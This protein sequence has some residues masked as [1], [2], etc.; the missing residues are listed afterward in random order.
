M[1]RDNMPFDKTWPFLLTQALNS[2]DVISRVQR[3]LTTNMFFG[4]S[5]KDYLEYY[6]PNIVVL[7][8]GIVD[9]APRY[10]KNGGMAMKV[11]GVLP[12]F[13]SGFIWK[14]IKK[15]KRRTVAN[16]DVSLD[17][18]NTNIIKYIER[19]EKCGV[20]KIIVVKIASPGSKMI[21]KNP[22]IGNQVQVYNA[23]YSAL[24]EKSKLI[25]L[26]D[27][28]EGVGDDYF[29]EDGYHLS[30]LGNK[31]LTTAILEELTSI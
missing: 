13:L 19:A 16:A 18:F 15:Y 22:G 21:E 6:Q 14:V 30:E 28:L 5:P 1:P 10:L 29:I 9:C 11:I 24:S 12:G 31:M 7:Q 27:T 26:I 25:K 3:A 17:K 4:G 8:V 23:V 20:E 2:F